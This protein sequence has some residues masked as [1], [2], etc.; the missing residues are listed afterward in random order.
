MP[1]ISEEGKRARLRGTGEGATYKPWILTR[2]INSWGTTANIIDWKHG[3]SVQLLSAGEEMYYYYLRW[4]DSVLDIREQ[5]PLDL[6]ATKKIAAQCGIRHPKGTM[7]TDLLVTYPKG[8]YV[9]YS[10]KASRKDVDYELGKT[11][12]EIKLAIRTAEKL[13]IEK[14]YWNELGVE[15]KL[16][17]KEDLNPVYIDNIRR[18]VVY[19]DESRVHDDVSRVKHLIATKQIE[20]DMNKPLDYQ[21]LISQHLK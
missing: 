17:L 21:K 2:E 18:V 4:D 15:W 1:V 20:V 19:Y 8:K 3:R 5:F 11:E 16:V 14:Y 9:A 12:S 6:E 7:T 13:F 10:V